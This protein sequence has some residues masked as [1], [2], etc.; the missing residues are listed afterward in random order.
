MNK[1]KDLKA[2]KIYV[3]LSTSLQMLTRSKAN[4]VKKKEKKSPDKARKRKV[5][6]DKALKQCSLSLC[7][8]YNFFS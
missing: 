1:K 6:R 8:H 5:N 2:M 4:S 3:T 7:N